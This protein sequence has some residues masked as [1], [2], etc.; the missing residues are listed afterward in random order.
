MAKEFDARKFMRLAI[1]AMKKSIPEARDDKASPKVGAV[2]VTPQ[3]EV[4]ASS[5]RGEMRNG[6]HAEYTLLDRK[7]R[8]KDVTGYYLFATLEPCA[9]GAR[10]HPKLGCAERI[11]NARIKKVWVG[12]EDP[13]P[14]VDRKG[15]MHLQNAGI[16]VEMFDGDMQEIILKEN[17]EFLNQAKLRKEESSK[18]KRVQLTTLENT[19][20]SAN[21]S[22]FSE[23]AL[24]HYINQAKLNTQPD[25]PD[26]L[27]LLEQQQLIHQVSIDGGPTLDQARINDVFP[28]FVWQGGLAGQGHLQDKIYN[29]G[30]R[31]VILSFREFDDN[32][33]GIQIS[34]GLVERDQFWTISA[35]SKTGEVNN[36][37]LSYHIEVF[38]HDKDKR[39]YRQ[40]FERR[41]NDRT[42]VSEAVLVQTP[43]SKYSPTGLGILLFGKNPRARYPQA[44]LK[45]EARYGKAEPEIHDFTDA[46]V[47]IPDKV[48]EWLKRILSSRISR[49]NFAR[50]TEYDYPIVVLREAIINAIVH[51]DYDLEGAKCY[52]NIDDDK[53][54]IMSPGLPVSPI[55]F[56]DFKR[57]K[58]PS[59]SRN[60]KLMAVFNSMNYVEERGI[61]MS[62]MKS[63]PQKHHLPQPDISWQE[64]Y[65]TITFPR[66]ANFI[67][68]V[69]GAEIFNQLNEEERAGLVFLREKKEVSKSQYAKHFKFKDDKKAQRHL[70]KFAEL[71]VVR[72]IGKGPA[73]RYVL[74]GE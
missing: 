16:E 27:S 32:K 74:I 38:F 57:F 60:P 61:G 64:P 14:T 73:S 52:L 29:K 65:L 11:V 40:E 63:L 28:L 70:T 5:F 20:V 72:L 43:E 49:D 31:A 4:V 15:I 13:D 45:V 58:A 6:D 9:P 56:E 33:S 22:E 47:L 7:L 25:S 71:G 67:E 36:S 48:E 44:V 8:D 68:S 59:L 55:K 46:L 34:K 39:I 21:I 24:R 50:T 3:G 54:V 66:S 35:Q 41:G 26:F 19:V 10:K 62:E 2:L 51:R 42:Q 17:K 53:I 1:D 37:L 18:P 12:I 23:E 30:D 69:V